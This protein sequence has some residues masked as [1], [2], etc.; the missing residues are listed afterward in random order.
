M[1]SGVHIDDE[2]FTLMKERYKQLYPELANNDKAITDALNGHINTIRK[3]MP[4][5]WLA[6]HLRTTTIP[7]YDLIGDIPPKMDKQIYNQVLSAYNYADSRL[8]QAAK[9]AE[10]ARSQAFL[11]RVGKNTAVGKLAKVDY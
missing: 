6:A 11:D 1:V 3:Q 5:L 7:K 9:N 4:V 2:H 10:V 8:Q